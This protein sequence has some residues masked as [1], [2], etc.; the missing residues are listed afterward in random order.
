LREPNDWRHRE[1]VDSDGCI[2]ANDRG[3]VVWEDPGEARQIA[4]AVIL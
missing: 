2:A 3:I 1:G 4:G